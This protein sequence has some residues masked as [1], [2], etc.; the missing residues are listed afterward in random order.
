[1]KFGKKDENSTADPKK[2]KEKKEKGDKDNIEVS[3][4][5]VGLRLALFI[6]AF[7]VA[8]VAF[9]YGVSRVIHRDEG[10]YD[11]S[12]EKNQE[13][14]MYSVGFHLKYYFTGE[15]AEIRNGIK[16]LGDVYSQV[17]LRSYK[18]LDAKNTYDG[19]S[20]IA[21]LNA[22]VGEEVNVGK[23]LY[24]ILA[25]AA[26]KTHEGVAGT[27]YNLFAGALFE[28]W[29][30]ILS[31]EAEEAAEFDP[32][33]NEKTAE[34]IARLA[35]M[36]SNPDYFDIEFLD[37]EKYTVKFTVADE[38][39][40]F[41]RENEYGTCILDPNLLADAYRLRIICSA[42]EENGYK[43]GYAYTASGLTVSLSE[44]EGGEYCM[45]GY[46]EGYSPEIIASAAVKRGSSA[47]L[48]RSFPLYDG[49][50]MYYEAGGVH[51]S[52]NI[53]AATGENGTENIA[54]SLALDYE[55]GDPVDVLY[56]NLT[57]FLGGKVPDTSVQ[58]AMTFYDAPFSV[59]TA[60]D[61]IKVTG[62]GVIA[63]EQR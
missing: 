19:Y 21:T 60:S 33:V 39:L 46:N 49:E 36:T 15:S 55:T 8:I 9:S 4:K 16:Q 62:K 42:L 34:R 45:Y 1:M 43:N 10:Y 5:H 63:G 28:E 30:A 48:L 50:I 6:V 7:T 57:A 24:G 11:I 25:D 2:I 56:A 13:T 29:N 17:L 52:P 32:S 14:P 51:R 26:E 47:S 38:Y 58:T 12:A 18:L 35:E 44:H 23:E 20:N 61:E 54:S 31:L 3:E 37:D 53:N 41:L 59:V 40:D 22:S 27:G